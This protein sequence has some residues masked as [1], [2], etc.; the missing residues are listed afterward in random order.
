M[1]T[2]DWLASMLLTR[3]AWTSAQALL[4]ICAVALIVRLWPR[5]PAAAR[6]ALWWLVG[7]Q[8][9][10]GLCWHAP[11]A[12][13]LP[14]PGPAAAVQAPAAM[15]VQADA[16]KVSTIA[17]MSHARVMTAHPA[18][19]ASTATNPLTR[20]WRIGLA[21]LW[22]LGV[23][24]Q[25]PLLWLQHRRTWWLRRTATAPTSDLQALCDEAARRMELHRAPKLLVS[26]H[27]ESPLVVGVWRPTVLWPAA[28]VLAR[29]EALLVLAHELAHVRR[30]DAMSSW[31]PVLSQRLFFF[32]PW[33]YLAARRYAVQREAA[34]DAMAVRGRSTDLHAYAGLLLRLGV[35][36]PRQFGLA[37]ASPTFRNLRQRL[38]ILQQGA[39]APSLRMWLLVGCV[40]LIGAMPYR[41]VAARSTAATPPAI[42]SSSAKSAA[43]STRTASYVYFEAPPMPAM[44]P[45]PPMPPM[46][47]MPPMPPM[48]SMPPMP[49]MPPS[50]SGNH[51]DIDIDSHATHGMALFDGGTVTIYGTDADQAAAKRLH[52]GGRRLLYFRQDN[53]AWVSYDPA[54]IQRAEKIHAPT[55]T[56]A[57]QQGQ[58][59]G[60]QGQLAGEQAGLAARE[61]NLAQLQ[62]QL[63]SRQAQLD[64]LKVASQSP[65]ADA[66]QRALQA[67]QTS[68][69]QRQQSL[70]TTVKHKK[71]ALADQQRALAAQQQEL[72][73]R[74]QQ[75]SRQAAQ[76][77][78]ALIRQAIAKGTAQRVD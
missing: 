7:L 49:P 61:A 71:Q 13:P 44:P 41:V 60:K 1:A 72:A 69:T 47:S 48:P 21:A 70:E 56:L 42:A 36:H 40:A 15:A 3:L 19:V 73:Q 77:M 20:H 28:L 53:K 33:V 26:A 74:Q 9:L 64:A 57:A 18:H 46:P 35:G 12:L 14:L 76:Q 24:V 30:A 51:V 17:A 52:E 38:H 50:I 8:L 66:Q 27:I 55:T 22:L 25:I 39:A 54:T 5:L 75:A 11:I 63:A 4:L 34:C 78:D 32:H 16:A 68:L 45:M 31:I 37:G 2:L 58:L 29:N 6:C 43:Q 67:E 10:L 59:A 23:L 65:Q 62:A